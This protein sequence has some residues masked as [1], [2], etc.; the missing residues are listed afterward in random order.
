MSDTIHPDILHLEACNFVDKPTGGQ[1]NFSR[2]L[3]KV[4]GNRLAL[5]GWASTSSEPIGCWF[6]KVIDGTVYRYFAIGMH[7]QVDRKPLV[8]SR[9][10]TWFQI[11]RHR[12]R[13]FSIG[14]KNI[15]V[16]EPAILMAMKM[17]SGYNLCFFNPGVGSPLTVSRYAWAKYF[18]SIYDFLFFQSLCR[19]ANCIL[20]AADESAIAELKHREGD[21]LQNINIISF[22]TRVD[23]DVYHPADCIAARK[24]LDLPA[25][26]VVVVTTG[27]IHWAKGWKLLLESFKLFLDRFPDSLLIFLG[28]GAEREVLEKHTLALGLRENIV[29]A[30]YQ[31]PQVIATYLQAANLFVMG[32]IQEGW[33]TVLLEALACRVPIVTTRFSSADTIVQHGINGFVVDRDPLEFSNAM[34]AALCLPGVALYAGSVIDRYALDRLA[35]DLFRVWPLIK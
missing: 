18:S 5:V 4:L 26:K 28:D 13:I 8:P 24:T 34:V 30:G 27:R 3:I 16:R 10:T 20:A 9:I 35:H 7:S 2:Q 22:P 31:S 14:I 23:T 32:S 33:S 1:L 6:N 19:K 17:Q 21:K 12:H 25:D 11:R 29:V 15:I